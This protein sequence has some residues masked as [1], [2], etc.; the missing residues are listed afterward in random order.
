MNEALKNLHAIVYGRVQGVSF[1]HYTIQKAY[2]LDIHGWVMNKRDGTVEVIAEGTENA[3]TQLLDFLH[4]GSPA[5]KVE[6]VE[7]EWREATG[8]FTNFKTRYNLT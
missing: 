2:S 1:R 7:H 5:A 3:L 6:R 8:E 4:Q